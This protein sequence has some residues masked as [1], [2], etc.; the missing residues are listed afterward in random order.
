MRGSALVMK[1]EIALEQHT[2]KGASGCD[3]KSTTEDSIIA[4]HQGGLGG[5]K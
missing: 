2:V 1:R 5:G 4:C 3:W